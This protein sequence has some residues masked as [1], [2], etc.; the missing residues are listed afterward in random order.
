MRMPG[1]TAEAGFYRI[2]KSYHAMQNQISGEQALI[3]QFGSGT[4]R[5]GWVCYPLMGCEYHC[6]FYPF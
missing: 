5:C 4:T 3:P 6:Q 2:S 1:F